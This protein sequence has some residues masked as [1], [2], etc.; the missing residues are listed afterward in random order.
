MGSPYG[1]A[2]APTT[3]SLGQSMFV[4]YAQVVMLLGHVK[5]GHAGE[6]RRPAGKR[7]GGQWWCSQPRGV[8]ALRAVAGR[9]ARCGSQIVPPR[10]RQ[11]P[12]TAS[13]ELRVCVAR[14][15]SPPPGAMEPGREPVAGAAQE[16]A[17]ARAAGGHHPGGTAA[18]GVLRCDAIGIHMPPRWTHRLRRCDFLVCVAVVPRR[19]RRAE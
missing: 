7:E 6:E 18:R 1:A 15:Q 3:L 12:P 9:G 13:R 2:L 16:L 14:A 8:Q 4:V 11:G 19:A 5:C 17:A 10:V